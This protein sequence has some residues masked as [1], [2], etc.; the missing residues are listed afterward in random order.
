MPNEGPAHNIVPTRDERKLFIVLCVTAGVMLLEVIGGYLSGSLALLADAGHMFTDVAGLSMSW[1][2]LRLGRRAPDSQRTYGYQRF[3]IV[4][5]YTNGVLLFFLCFVIASEAIDRL[6]NPHEVNGPLMMVIAIIGLITNIA[7][8]LILKGK[9]THLF[10]FLNHHGH[11][12]GHGN[13]HDDHGHSH[14]HSHEKG[15]LNI[16]SAALHILS[17]L[18]GSIGTILAGIIIMLTGWQLADPLLSLVIAVLIFFYA[19]GLIKRTVHILVEG[20]PDE[21]LPEKMRV[22]LMAN[23]KGLKDVHHI[24]VWSLTE[25]QPLA[26]LHVTIDDTTDFQEALC[27]IRAFLEEKFDLDH[28]TIQIEK[29]PCGTFDI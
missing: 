5:A 1:F 13:T 19:W 12:H 27:A 2:A 6:N 14:S 9:G 24:H 26:T 20:A 15:D 23:I 17:D 22:A 29:G 21:E 3:K 11:D 4:A 25:K 28:A 16:Q 7:G 8:F 18:L 10:D